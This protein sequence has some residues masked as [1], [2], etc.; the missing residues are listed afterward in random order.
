MKGCLYAILLVIA[1]FIIVII[2]SADNNGNS[3]RYKTSESG[4]TAA[5]TYENLLKT[6]RYNVHV[7]LKK[8][9]VGVGSHAAHWS[10]K[11]DEYER[12]L[13]S[14]GYSQDQIYSLMEEADNEF[15]VDNGN[16][17]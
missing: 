5:E 13:M 3:L 11:Y 10:K 7:A 12:L 8:G 17:W 9:E 4:D 2:F 1:L 15:F 14:S 6:A 16:K